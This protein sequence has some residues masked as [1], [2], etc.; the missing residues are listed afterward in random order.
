MRAVKYGEPTDAIGMI[1]IAADNI[2]T[3]QPWTG[4]RVPVSQSQCMCS[5]IVPWVSIDILG[6]GV[7]R[8]QL[9]TGFVSLRGTPGGT[10]VEQ[11]RCQCGI[12][13]LFGGTSSKL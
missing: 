10:V 6:G 2:Q 9:I 3:R 8:E 12:G 1:V 5:R 4:I 11:C 13:V 7:G